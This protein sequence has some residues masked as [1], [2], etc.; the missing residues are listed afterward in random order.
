MSANCS[1]S[2]GSPRAAS[3]SDSGHSENTPARAAVPGF[4]LNECRGSVD[5]V[6]G[7]PSAV[8]RATSWTR[9][10][11]ATSSGTLG[12]APSRLKWFIRSVLMAST[13]GGRAIMLPGPAS[14]PSGP[15]TTMSWNISP[16]LSASSIRASRSSTRWST[17]SA[18]S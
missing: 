9:L 3:P 11:Q 13:V 12:T 17:S 6:T 18:G 16:A 8:S 1:T 14:V 15:I 5:I 10:C 7:M 4:E 2:A